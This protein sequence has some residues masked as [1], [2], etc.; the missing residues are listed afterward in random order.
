MTVLPNSISSAFLKRFHEVQSF[1]CQ[2]HCCIAV[3]PSRLLSRF[4]VFVN[5]LGRKAILLPCCNHDLPVVWPA[6][7]WGRPFRHPPTWEALPGH[8]LPWNWIW[9]SE[10]G[11]CATGAN[12]SQR[13]SFRLGYWLLLG[14]VLCVLTGKHALMNK[15]GNMTNISSDIQHINPSTLYASKLSQGLWTINE[16][17]ELSA[18][19]INNEKL[20]PC[21]LRYV[22]KIVSFHK[23]GRGR[24]DFLHEATLW[25]PFGTRSF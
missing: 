4:R 24:I 21:S 18:S 12:S 15:D 6:N 13:H 17:F 11:R 23:L 14:A 8:H 7:F 19:I 9:I 2:N 16:I 10:F 22:E 1:S 3:L 20:R 25:C 5:K